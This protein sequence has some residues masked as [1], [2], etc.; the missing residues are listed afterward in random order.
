MYAVKSGGETVGYSD[1]FVFI[2]LHSNGCYV[3]CSEAE[4]EGICIKIA[5]QA[6]NENGETVTYIDDTVFKL[7][8][9]G[10]HG[11]E[12]TAELETVSGA[13]VIADKDNEINTILAELESE[14]GI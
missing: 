4:A 14:A 5:K 3:L 11:S 13:Q 1:G 10:L 12:P 7:T 9:T 6:V 2:R 8:E